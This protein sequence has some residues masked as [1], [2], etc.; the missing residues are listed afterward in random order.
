[1]PH[2]WIKQVVL[3][4]I[5]FTTNESDSICSNGSIFL[6]PDQESRSNNEFYPILFLTQFSSQKFNS[7]DVIFPDF[8]QV[9]EILFGTVNLFRIWGPNFPEGSW[10]IISIGLFISPDNV[11][12]GRIV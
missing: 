9:N 3:G 1:M 8:E 10:R 7:I 5:I 12:I 11:I 6:K 2:G 4:G